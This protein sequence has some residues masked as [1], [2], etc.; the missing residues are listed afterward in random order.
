M[1]EEEGFIFLGKCLVFLLEMSAVWIRCSQ[2]LSYFRVHGHWRSQSLFANLAYSADALQKRE[3]QECQLHM[4]GCPVVKRPG[5][6][7]KNLPNVEK[8]NTL[9]AQ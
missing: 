7:R 2:L 1:S 8:V 9:K 4:R 6:S 5:V 3:P